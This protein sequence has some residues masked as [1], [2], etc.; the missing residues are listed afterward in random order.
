MDLTAK[1]ADLQLPLGKTDHIEW[2]D[3]LKGFG[4]RMRAGAG[5]TVLRSWIAQYRRAG[6]TRRVLLGSAAV[7]TATKARAAA[8]KVLAAVTLG[9]DPQADRVDRRAKD[10]HSFRSV[11]D[12]YLK[13]KK[14]NVRGRTLIEIERY[15]TGRYFKPLHAMPL[16]AIARKDIAARLVVITRESSSIVAASARDTLNA[17]FIWAMQMGMVEQNPVTG[18]IKPKGSEGRSQV[19]TDAELAAIWRACEDDDH[20]RIVRLMVLAGAR[21]Q[22][23]GGM[24]WSE[25]DAER[26]TWTLPRERAKNKHAHTLLLP[27]AAWEI[28]HAVPR[29][30]N[31]DHLFGARAERGFT[32]WGTAK[33]ELDRSLGSAVEPFVLHDI[34]RSV[35]TKLADLGVAPHVI[36]QILNH[37][38]GHKRGVAGVYNRSSYEREV[39]A[40]LAMWADHVRALIDGSEKIVHI[41]PLGATHPR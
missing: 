24:R 29:M 13:A 39:R 17:F 38:G 20:G 21:R 32:A 14:A 16:D 6:R 26:G 40:A 11:V 2:D 30:A 35:A 23:I 37:Q 5:G 3:A 25:L 36:E 27:P 33:A 19:L 4:Y 28:I 15:L 12:E 22:E 1:V 34:R 41:L 8:E 7:L 9:Q 10:K 18:T 31:R